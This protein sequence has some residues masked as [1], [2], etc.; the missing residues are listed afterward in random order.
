MRHQSLLELVVLVALY[1]ILYNLLLPLRDHHAV[2]S[3]GFWERY[4]NAGKGDYRSACTPVITTYTQHMFPAGFDGQTVCFPLCGSD[5][6]MIYVFERGANVIGIDAVGAAA[7]HLVRRA[8]WST[9]DSTMSELA[10]ELERRRDV[11]TGAQ[12][13]R[14]TEPCEE[15]STP[16][17][18]EYIVG[19]VF[20]AGGLMAGRCDV[21]IDRGGLTAVHP[22]YRP[23]CA[24]LEAA[25]AKQ[26]T[27][28]GNAGP[29]SSRMLLVALEPRN[30]SSATGSH[31]Y[32][33]N[34]L[35]PYP[36]TEDEVRAL[37]C[38]RSRAGRHGDCDGWEVER[39][40]PPWGEPTRPRG[41]AANTLVHAV[42]SLT[43]SP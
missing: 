29:S 39:L 40:S 16:H 22:W 7:E 14:Y 43:R 27:R 26:A 28:N 3:A 33:A 10:M 21:I 11:T 2:L 18:F 35:P 32:D 41:D 1:L 12:V 15:C 36:V 34:S 30:S 8:S 13:I 4:Y 38:S 17:T 20:K 5:L 25:M 24:A 42:Y 9:S 37:Y 6:D 31:A 19:D 23:R